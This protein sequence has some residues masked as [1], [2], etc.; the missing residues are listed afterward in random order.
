VPAYKVSITRVAERDIEECVK[1]I[2]RDNRAAAGKWLGET[3][4]RIGILEKFPE[5]A[6]RI[7]E[8]SAIGRD[9]RH[10]VFGNYRI[11]FRVTGKTVSVMRV[12]HSARLL[13]LDERRE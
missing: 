6:P 10:L 1:Y 12:I 13:Q 3:L 11:V 9:Y 5:R 2:S 4:D 8:S 7:P